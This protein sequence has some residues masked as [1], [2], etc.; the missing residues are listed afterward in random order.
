[1]FKKKYTVSVLDSKWG[2]IKNSL[3]LEIIPR[4]N[5]YLWLSDKYYSVISVVHSIQEK[6]GVFLIVEEQKNQPML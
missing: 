4:I 1:M 3:K 5:E 6:N 2:I